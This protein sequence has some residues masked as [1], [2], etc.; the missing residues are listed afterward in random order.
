[1]ANGGLCIVLPFPPASLSGHAKG[2][3]RAR[4]DPTARQRET[5]CLLTRAALRRHGKLVLP[6][7]GDIPIRVTFIPP[8]RRGDRWNF[9]ARLKAAIDGVADGLGVNDKRFLPTI[10]HGEPEKPGRVEVVVG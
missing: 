10:V 9:P 4:S 1:M 8:D 6:A 2:H 7:T 5:G 3:W